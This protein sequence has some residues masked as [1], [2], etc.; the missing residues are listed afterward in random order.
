MMRNFLIILALSIVAVSCQ[1]QQSSISYL[2]TKLGE[3]TLA[4]ERFQISENE[5][6]ADVI[7]RS[8]ITSLKSYTLTWNEATNIQSMNVTDHTLK[9]SFKEEGQTIQK[10]IN[11]GDSLEVIYITN[12]GDRVSQLPNRENLIPFIDMVHWPYEIAFKRA[13]LSPNDSIDQYMITGRRNSN[14]IIHRL[15]DISYSLRHPS[16]GVMQVTTSYEGELM[17][18]DA[19]ATTRKVK[20]ERAFDLEFDKLANSLTQ[21]DISG[22]TFGSLSPAVINKYHFADTYFQVSYGSPAK[23]GREIFGGIVSY[24]ERWRTGANRATHFK[25]SSDLTIQG[26]NLPAGEYTLFTIPEKDGGTLII[27]QQIGQNGRSYD[28]FQDIM[29][30]EMS[31]SD[32][33]YEIES[34]TIT[35]D[36]TDSGGRLG[37]KWDQTIYYIDFS[38]NP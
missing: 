31:R 13:H 15:D 37:L 22:S 36:E 32:Y 30:V 34:F 23:R 38:I 26:K 27:N 29:R 16:R 3:D 1:N 21:R 11:K 28:E 19:K 17:S 12:K 35:I 7:L 33:N 2:I 24:G 9:R 14:F 6:K 25:S 4:I 8:P 20:V 10:I 18:L 5:M